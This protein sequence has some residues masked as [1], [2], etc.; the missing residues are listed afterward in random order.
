MKQRY[1]R[2]QGETEFPSLHPHIPVANK[3]NRYTI[4]YSNRMEIDAIIERR[5]NKRI[6]FI[7]RALENVSV[8]HLGRRVEIVE[9]VFKS[10]RVCTL[11]D[12][13]HVYENFVVLYFS[14]NARREYHIDRHFAGVSARGYVH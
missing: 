2:G 9:P 12:C 8:P 6:K 4:I 5:I 10:K 11:Y 7:R 1:L 13:I 3:N 14:S